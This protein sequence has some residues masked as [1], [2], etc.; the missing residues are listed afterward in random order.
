MPHSAPRFGRGGPGA[1]LCQKLTLD[2]GGKSPNIKMGSGMEQGTQ[3]GPLVSEEQFQR[4]SGLL[5][6]GLLTLDAVE[7][8]RGTQR[9][10]SR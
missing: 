7:S 4:V 9:T 3:M 8:G 5:D 1:L 6:A 10:L 2:P